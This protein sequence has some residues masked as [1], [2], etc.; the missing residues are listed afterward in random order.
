MFVLVEG[1]F[2]TRWKLL[3]RSLTLELIW[4]EKTAAMCQLA[5]FLCSVRLELGEKEGEEFKFI[6][7]HEMGPTRRA[8]RLAGPLV[9]R[10]SHG[11]FFAPSPP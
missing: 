4:S 11:Q 5:T 2:L 9:R 6:R 8:S 10:S 7:S 1:Q 3:T